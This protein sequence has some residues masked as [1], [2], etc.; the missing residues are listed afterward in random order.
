VNAEAATPGP[1]L[2]LTALAA[3]AA[4]FLAVVSGATDGAVAHRVLATLGIPLLAAVAATALTAYPALRAPS[5]AALALY[6]ATSVHVGGQD[7]HLALAALALAASLVAT[8]S[9][10]SR[11]P[12]WPAVTCLTMSVSSAAGG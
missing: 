1:W 10:F 12:T 4:C 5:L 11:S 8:A 7:A 2:R 9:T 3:S 6:G